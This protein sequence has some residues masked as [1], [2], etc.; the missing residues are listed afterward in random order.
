MPYIYNDEDNAPMSE[1]QLEEVNRHT[2]NRSAVEG[3]LDML[4]LIGGCRECAYVI[5]SIEG[6]LQCNGLISAEQLQF[7]QLMCVGCHGKG[8]GDIQPEHKRRINKDWQDRR[9][10]VNAH[11]LRC[12][13]LYCPNVYRIYGEYKNP[14]DEWIAIEDYCGDC[15]YYE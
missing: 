2:G 14:D 4:G 1:S 6:F 10:W 11:G 8:T 5:D 7:L 9:E 15:K 12:R 3:V 13:C